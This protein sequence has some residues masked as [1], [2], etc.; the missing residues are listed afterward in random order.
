MCQRS[1]ASWVWWSWRGA[2]A[3]WCVRAPV[4]DATTRRVIFDPGS[5]RQQEFRRLRGSCG[6]WWWRGAHARRCVRAPV[7]ARAMSIRH[8]R[9][10]DARPRGACD[11]IPSASGG[12]RRAGAPAWSRDRVHLLCLNLY[13]LRVRIRQKLESSRNALSADDGRGAERSRAGAIA[14]V[15]HDVERGGQ[16]KFVHGQTRRRVEFVAAAAWGVV[17]PVSSAS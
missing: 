13:Q 2:H 10:V 9:Q 12:R 17:A 6:W 16:I 11:H 4:L 1:R 14:P 5:H 8:E 3:R 7:R 15:S